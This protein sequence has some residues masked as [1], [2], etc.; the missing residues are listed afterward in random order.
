MEREK[1]RISPDLK[2]KHAKFLFISNVNFSRKDLKLAS[3][4]TL[5]NECEEC[6]IMFISQT[7]S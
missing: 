6:V 3:F 5:K 7:K 2:Y 1:I 4:Y